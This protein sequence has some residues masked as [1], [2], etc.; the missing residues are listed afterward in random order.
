LGLDYANTAPRPA[1]AVT[2]Q[3]LSGSNV[4]ATTTTDAG[5]GYSFSVA[6]DTNVALRVRA[7]MVRTGA[8]GWDF[9]VVDNVSSAALYAL[10]GAVFN[11]GATALRR[12]VHAASGW[13]GSS[14]TGARSAAPFAILDVVYEAAQFVLTVAPSSSFPPLV[15]NWST[16]NVPVDGSGPGEIGGSFYNPSLGIFLLGAADTDTDEYD[17]HVIAHEWAHYFEDVFSRSDSFGGPHTLS[18]QL[19]P[20]VAFGEGWGNAFSAMVAANPIYVDAFGSGQSRSFSFDIEGPLVPGRRNPNPGWFNEESIQSLLYDLY[21]AHA[22]VVP[23]ST[24][25]D[26][27]AL[28]FAPLYA[29]L[30]DQ[31]RTT[32]ALTSVFPFVNALKSDRPADAP[33]IDALTDSQ[34]IGTVVD[35]YGSGET[36]FGVP[37]S[38]DL[39]SV[40][41]QLAVGAGTVNVCSL[42]DFTSVATGATNKLGSR[43][44]I[45]FTVTNPGV[46]VISAATTAAP[47]NSA[48]DP[49]MILHLRGFVQ[50]ADGAPS[51]E[52]AV[53]PQACIETFAPS[54]SAGDY[55]LE[56]YEWTNTNADDDPDYPPI[57]RTCFDVG[58]TRQ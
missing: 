4:L 42:D 19:D 20:R 38:M 14:Y 49:D 44:F 35:D 17:R 22:D 33:L 39:Q 37:E 54:L 25:V 30:T 7:E 40:Y 1:R 15:L 6:P 2:V 47:P 3:L 41:T 43:R 5:G 53:T 48:P 36:N 10:D 16:L 55:V 52:C 27:L 12:D 32:S 11:T 34:S 45:R 13:T 57:G 56:V 24:V 9:R 50:R 23:N 51:A 29:V 31:Q 18:D 28:G 21:D 26:N 46:H 58:V 8:P